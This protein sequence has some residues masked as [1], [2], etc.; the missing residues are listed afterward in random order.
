MT[1]DAENREI[2]VTNTNPGMQATYAHNGDGQR[3]TKAIAGG[4]PTI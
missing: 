2:S 1:Y 4:S 3:V